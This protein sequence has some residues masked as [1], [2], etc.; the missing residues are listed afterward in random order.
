MGFSDVGDSVLALVVEEDCNSVDRNS[1]ARNSDAMIP[2]GDHHEISI[3]KRIT[4]CYLKVLCIFVL[5]FS[6]YKIATKCKMY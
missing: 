6:D 5:R 3:K 4:K 2:N 1:A